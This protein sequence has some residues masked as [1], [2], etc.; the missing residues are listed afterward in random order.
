MVF[1]PAAFGLEGAID[2]S[3]DP[4]QQ[5]GVHGIMPKKPAGKLK[6]ERSLVADNFGFA[7]TYEYKQTEAY[8]KANSE[9]P[10]NPLTMF[11]VSDVCSGVSTQ[12]WTLVLL[13][14]DICTRYCIYMLPIPLTIT[15]H[16]YINYRHLY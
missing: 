14:S 9:N 11:G 2:P 12:Y 10:D 15:G 6:L 13:I 8:L 16:L 5:W 7:N 1:D 4:Q 3:L